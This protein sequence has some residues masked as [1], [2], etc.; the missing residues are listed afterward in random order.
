MNT[1]NDQILTENKVSL[2]SITEN[3]R[4]IAE[5]PVLLPNE[6]NPRQNQRT[7]KDL[8]QHFT[9]RQKSH[10]SQ[11]AFQA[12]KWV[13]DANIK[14]DEGKEPDNVPLPVKV[15]GQEE[16]KLRV[17]E[18]REAG[19]FTLLLDEEAGRER[20]KFEAI[21]RLINIL[22]IFICFWCSNL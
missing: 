22:I 16:P 17:W 1:M 13:F 20:E 4:K 3:M 5:N 21:D 12:K 10:V 8:H 9:Q 7:L 14:F 2:S 6:Q 15:W 19:K 18:A 11:D